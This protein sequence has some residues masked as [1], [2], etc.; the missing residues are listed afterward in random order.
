M[1]TQNHSRIAEP[2]RSYN[3]SVVH[4]SAPIY[5]LPTP[6][7]LPP[8]GQWEAGVD[9]LPEP[10]PVPASFPAT[11]RDLVNMDGELGHDLFQ[12]LLL[13]TSRGLQVLFLSQPWMRK[14]WC[15]NTASHTP[16]TG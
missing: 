13:C 7:V 2:L 9:P 14:P 5:G 4:A 6:A 11:L 10:G 16:R 8:L 12:W 15:T 1:P 3:R